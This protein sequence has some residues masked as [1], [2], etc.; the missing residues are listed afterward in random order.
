MTDNSEN[1]VAL[2]GSFE[3]SPRE[4]VWDSLTASFGNPRTKTERSMFG[5]V[6]AE[7]L[8]AGATSAET[9]KACEYVLATFDS[10][11]VN[12]VPKWFS[13]AQNGTAKKSA[14]QI[15]FDQLRGQA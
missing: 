9:Q 14:Q 11:S 15:A 3:K 4:Q 13:V 10:P 5:R 7:L 8:E 2:N 1:V 6:V 12:A